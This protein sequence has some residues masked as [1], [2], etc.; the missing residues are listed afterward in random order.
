[1]SLVID[2]NVWVSAADPADPLSAP[3]QRFLE[4]VVARRLRV[5]LPITARLEVACALARR[6]RNPE[7]GQSLANALIDAPM[8]SERAVDATLLAAAIRIGTRSFLRAADALYAAVGSQDGD[9]LVSWDAELMQ[10]ATARS[11]SDWLAA[12]S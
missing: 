1:M 8:I 10:R 5:V 2:A 12:H 4:T 7:R 6:L 11:P 9:E 3:S